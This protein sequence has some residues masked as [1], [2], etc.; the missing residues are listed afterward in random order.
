MKNRLITNWE[1]SPESKFEDFLRELKEYLKMKLV[2]KKRQGITPFWSCINGNGNEHYNMLDNLR[3]FCKI[4]KL[5]WEEVKSMIDQ[6]YAYDCHCD[7]HI[8]QAME[9]AGIQTNRRFIG[10]MWRYESFPD[11]C[12][13][14]L[15]MP[16]SSIIKN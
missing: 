10:G 6:Y 11:E 12:Y 15:S 13:E 7:C 14:I 9:V 8:L 4:H 16:G 3:E 5:D 1:L 2:L